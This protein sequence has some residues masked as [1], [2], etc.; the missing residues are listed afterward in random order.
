MVLLDERSGYTERE[1]FDAFLQLPAAQ[2]KI[3]RE[4]ILTF[5]KAN[6]VAEVH[7]QK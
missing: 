6:G 2:R 7:A 3:I 5:A 1:T 4:V